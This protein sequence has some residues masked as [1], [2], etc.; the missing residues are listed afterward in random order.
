[1]RA[2]YG[3]GGS[4]SLLGSVIKFAVKEALSTTIDNNLR[5]DTNIVFRIR[6]RF[7]KGIRCQ[8]CVMICPKNV[9]TF[10]NGKIAIDNIQKCKFCGL[11][12]VACPN[13]CITVKK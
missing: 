9:L 4:D 13:D 2:R 8:K 12:A 11:C 3:H 1:M 7:C 6:T 10:K 5:N